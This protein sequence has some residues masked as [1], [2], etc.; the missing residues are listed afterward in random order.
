[1]Y[2]EQETIGFIH[3]FSKKIILQPRGIII[4]QVVIGVL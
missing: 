1:M 3:G 2:K 4:I